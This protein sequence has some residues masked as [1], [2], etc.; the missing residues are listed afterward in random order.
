MTGAVRTGMGIAGTTPRIG[1][2]RPDR[3]AIGAQQ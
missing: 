1:M 3:P 2:T